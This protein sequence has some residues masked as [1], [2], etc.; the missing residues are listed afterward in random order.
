MPCI[1]I[2]EPRRHQLPMRRLQC[3][4]PELRRVRTRPYEPPDITLVN[5]NLM[6]VSADGTFDQQVYLPLGLLYNSACLQRDGYNVEFVDYQLFSHAAKFDRDLFAEAL[7]GL[8]PMVGISCMSNLL[9]FSISVAWRIKE[10]RPDCRIVFGGVGPSPV[11]SELLRA[12]PFID[13]VVEG[14]GEL[15]MLDFMSGTLGA[16][17]P[18]RIVSDLDTLPLPAYNLVDFSLYDAAPS[19]ITSR[20]CPYK[21]TF[22]TEPYNFSGSV[23]FRSVESILEELELVNAR[24]GRTLFLFQ[25]DILP[26]KPSRFR[27]ILKG[28]RE[29]SFPIKWK[30]FSRV[31]L[32]SDNLMMEMVDSGCVQVRYGIESGSNRTLE[33]I[34][35]G[36]TIELAYEVA[37][38]SVKHFP[39]VHAS[40][41]WGYPFEQ[42]EEFEETL[43]AIERFEEA[44]VTVLLFEYSPLPG[45]PLYRESAKDSLHFSKEAYSFFVVTGH[46]LC[47]SDGYRSV[48]EHSSVYDLIRDYPE[49]FSGFYRHDTMG[50]LEKRQR[51]RQFGI[52][53]RSPLMNEYD[54]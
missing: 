13:C 12:F 54:L 14:E 38:R 16:R 45:S 51:L 33:R 9:P 26:L 21:C 35:K 28:L 46:E 17:P 50:I 7:G 24:S 1:R 44:G 42:V 32:M 30:C 11:A 20:G 5:L 31:D 3:E 34:R 43:R 36:F 40:F 18:V 22:C 23:R 41:I 53:R 48:E 37:A 6:L 10:A 15:N 47:G 4:E 2:P 39:S 19:I 52:T 29:L 27:K 49:I 8:A 25:D